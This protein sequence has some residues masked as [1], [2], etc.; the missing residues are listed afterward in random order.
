MSRGLGGLAAEDK[1]A[2]LVPD[3]GHSAARAGPWRQRTGRAELL[4]RPS[5]CVQDPKILVHMAHRLAFCAL[6]YPPVQPQRTVR[7]TRESF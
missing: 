7:S 1:K 5:R 4:P 6:L 3:H 2:A